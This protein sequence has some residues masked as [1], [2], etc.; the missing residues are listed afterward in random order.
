MLESP[1]TDLVSAGVATMYVGN[2][3]IWSCTT[4]RFSRPM[5]TTL[6]PMRRTGPE[7]EGDEIT[8]GTT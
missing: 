8:T 4:S 1:A 5:P 3:A 6:S 7:P 2:L